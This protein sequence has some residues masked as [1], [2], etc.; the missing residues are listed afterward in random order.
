MLSL[1]DPQ[2]I[3]SLTA[4]AGKPHEGG[5]MESFQEIGVIVYRPL[6]EDFS[7]VEGEFAL[8]FYRGALAREVLEKTDG[9]SDGFHGVYD[10]KTMTAKGNPHP[11]A[12]TGVLTI[13]PMDPNEQRSP[14]GVCAGAH[15]VIWDFK[16]EPWLNQASGY[17]DKGIRLKYVGVGIEVAGAKTP[18][19]AA[20]WA[21]NMFARTWKVDGAE[22]IQYGVCG[23][24]TPM[25]KARRASS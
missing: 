1:I 6:N 23:T 22:M 7:R 25:P 5:G 4:A 20:A 9:G 14:D 11:V 24:P 12:A 19:M 8:P 10:M 17:A 16:P 3:Q 2:L 13:E 15:W 18:L 21:N